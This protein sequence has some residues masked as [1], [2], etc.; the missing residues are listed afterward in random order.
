MRS[1][2]VKLPWKGSSH[3]CFGKGEDVVLRALR[4]RW[5]GLCASNQWTFLPLHSLQDEISYLYSP[6]SMPTSSIA[7][8]R[9]VAHTGDKRVFRV[10]V[11]VGRLGDIR[12][13]T[14]FRMR[15]ACYNRCSGGISHNV[16]AYIVSEN[17]CIPISTQIF[18]IT[19]RN[20]H[21]SDCWHM[22]SPVADN[23]RSCTS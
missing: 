20:V 11:T 14:A 2:S 23:T 19:L 16:H 12:H 10:M 6:V 5:I 17:D 3:H 1:K 15:S 8:A 18:N 4:K 13:R 9:L 22:Q 7:S 21:S